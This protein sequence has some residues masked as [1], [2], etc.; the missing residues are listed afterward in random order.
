MKKI[1]QDKRLLALII[2]IIVVII[3]VVLLLLFVDEKKVVVC[4]MKSD[5]SRNGYVLETNYTI[6]AKGDYVE[7]VLIIETITSSNE[8]ILDKFEKQLTEQ[9]GSNKKNYKGYTYEVKVEKDKLKTNVKIDY[10]QFDLD[11]FIKDN[12]AMK[13]YTEDNKFTLD[14][15]IRLY[16]STGA[17]CE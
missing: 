8:T 6:N 7:D 15:A 10:N 17:K 5:Q 2:V 16:E 14:G 9:Y 13:D 11:K 3:C 12:V 4:H 1:I